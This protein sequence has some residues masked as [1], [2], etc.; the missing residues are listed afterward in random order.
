MPTKY[1][2]IC[3]VATHINITD[4]FV[5]HA[6][7]TFMSSPAKREKGGRGLIFN[8]ATMHLKVLQIQSS[9]GEREIISMET[10]CIYSVTC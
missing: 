2:A 4:C 10:F 5:V 9:A 7:Y 1:Y 8:I 6:V 3:M